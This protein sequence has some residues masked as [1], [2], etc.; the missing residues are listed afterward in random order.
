MTDLQLIES[1]DAAGASLMTFKQ[2]A[3]RF[4]VSEGTVRNLVK[5]GA[6]EIVWLDGI[7]RFDPVDVEAYIQRNKKKRKK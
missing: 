6:L 1:D 7:P 5:R 2:V 3:K 4:G